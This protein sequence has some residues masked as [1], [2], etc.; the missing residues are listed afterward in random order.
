MLDKKVNDL[1]L[2]DHLVINGVAIAIM[3][4]ALSVRP[5]VRTVGN[6]IKKIK[7]KNK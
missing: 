2:K 7:E 4:G 3:A 1:T 5:V 6:K